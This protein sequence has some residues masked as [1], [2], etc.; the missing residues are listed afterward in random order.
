LI[1]AQ[2]HAMD[3][4]NSAKRVDKSGHADER[5]F[6]S[7]YFIPQS[8][9]DMFKN[10]V[11]LCPGTKEHSTQDNGMDSDVLCTENWKTANTIH[12]DTAKVFK[13]TGIFISACRHGIVETFC[14]MYRSGEL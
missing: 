1:P 9:V 6:F 4:S 10:D 7:K 12:E 8:E 11:T 14:E 2:L 5:E 13:Q 3:G